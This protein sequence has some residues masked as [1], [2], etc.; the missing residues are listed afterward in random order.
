MWGGYRKNM[1]TAQRHRPVPIP[2]HPV[3]HDPDLDKGLMARRRRGV[4][5][6]AVKDSKMMHV[7]VT[8][9]FVALT[10]KIVHLIVAESAGLEDPFLFLAVALDVPV[11]VL[12]VVLWGDVLLTRSRARRDR[13][14]DPNG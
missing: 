8:C 2:A 9:V 6:S 3:G 12:M 5:R 11:L 13:S 7:L 14:D 10:A 4:Y 1:D